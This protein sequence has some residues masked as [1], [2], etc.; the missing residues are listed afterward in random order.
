MLSPTNDSLSLSLSLSLSFFLFLSFP[1][2]TYD[3]T[4]SSSPSPSFSLSLS[5]SLS[6]SLS[7]FGRFPSLFFLLLVWKD[8]HSLTF[9][10]LHFHLGWKV[11]RG[12]RLIWK[13]KWKFF[14]PYQV[15]SER[16][17]GD[18]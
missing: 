18:A 13:R 3:S 10:L 6:P 8:I 5:L 11:V 15:L 1:T 14:F 4:L 7:L 2:L 16:S 9:S 17:V 12:S